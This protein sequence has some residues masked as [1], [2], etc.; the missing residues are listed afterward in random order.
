MAKPHRK[1]LS[2]Y[3]SART[4]QWDARLQR[5][6]D[7]RH[8]ELDQARR[9]S[10]VCQGANDR[11]ADRRHICF[12]HRKPAVTEHVQLDASQQVELCRPID[13]RYPA[14]AGLA[15]SHVIRC[16]ANELVKYGS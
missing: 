14:P 10:R 11:L 13:G 4:R 2:P 6:V 15:S 1:S 16:N 7:R 8:H 12:L 3:F 9:L 5:G